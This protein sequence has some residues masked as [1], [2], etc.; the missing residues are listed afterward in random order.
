MAR[1]EQGLGREE[2]AGDQGTW[3]NFHLI[4]TNIL[5]VVELDI[6]AC[7]NSQN[8]ALQRTGFM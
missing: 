7:Q 6:D 4:E 2:R 8:S 1:G 3:G 5:V